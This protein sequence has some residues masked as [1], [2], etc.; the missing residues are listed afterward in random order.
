MTMEKIVLGA[1]LG[2]CVHVGG[3]AHF[4]QLAEREGYTPIYLGPAIPV[5]DLLREIELHHPAMVAVGYRLTP[6]MPAP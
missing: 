2:N 6:T 1:S 3:V 4:L 5:D